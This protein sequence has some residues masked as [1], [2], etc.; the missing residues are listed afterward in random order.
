MHL[1]RNIYTTKVRQRV[2]GQQFDRDV[3]VSQ[4]GPQLCDRL[5]C[6]QGRAEQLVHT[7]GEVMLL[8]C[9]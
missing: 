7:S 8:T 6:G 2:V 9:I 5:S 3:R 1:G 4:T